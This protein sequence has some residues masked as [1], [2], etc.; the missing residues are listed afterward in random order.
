MNPTINI[1]MC[2]RATTRNVPSRT[3]RHRLHPRL[4]SHQPTRTHNRDTTVSMGAAAAYRREG[5]RC[6]LSVSSSQGGQRGP[7]MLERMPAAARN[8]SRQRQ[9]RT[10]SAPAALHA[11]ARVPSQHCSR[12]WGRASSLATL[13]IDFA[14]D[15]V[16]R[17]NDGNHVGQHVALGHEVEA[18]QVREAGCA[19][20]AAVWPVGAVR[21]EVDAELALGRLARGVR[22]AWRRRD[23]LRVE[24]E[25]VDER[26]HVALHLVARRRRELAVVGLDEP[27]LEQVEALHDHMRRLAHLLNADEVA[28]KT[29]TLGARR[30]LELELRI[31]LIWLRLA[32]V[33]RH[34]RA[35][36]HHA[37]E[38]PIQCLVS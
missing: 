1:S 3:L 33:P 16:L 8:K 29:I 35:A 38:A 34:A 22:L 23:A 4:G 30:D 27:W 19:D 14:E 12:P 18:L 9:K 7:A 32:Q 21:D 15:D 2:T 28:V 17:A 36:Q 10:T 24:L 5:I 11:P 25:V 6:Q 20:F 26:L 37:G 31:N 13:P